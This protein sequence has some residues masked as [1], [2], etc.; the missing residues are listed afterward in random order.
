[1]LH[2][3][4]I[5]SWCKPIIAENFHLSKILIALTIVAF[6]TSAPEFAVSIKSALDGTSD[7]VLGNVIGSNILNILLIQQNCHFE[8]YNT[9]SDE[10]IHKFPATFLLIQA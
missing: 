10:T 8:A 7:I 6:G 2:H 5:F 3:K 1:M 9:Y 4:N